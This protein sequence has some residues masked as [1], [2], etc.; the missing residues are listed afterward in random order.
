MTVRKHIGYIR[1][2]F[3][4]ECFFIINQL[5]KWLSQMYY[6]LFILVYSFLI[7]V[8][9]GRKSVFWGR[10]RFKRHQNSSIRI[11]KYCMFISKQTGNLLGLSKPCIVSTHTESAR[12]EIGDNCSFSGTSIS[13]FTSVVLKN[14][15][16]CGANT[17]IT[18]SDWHADDPRS[19]GSAP[20]CIGENVWLGMGATVLKGVTI[21]KNSLIGANSLVVKDIPENVIAAGNPCKVVRELP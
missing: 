1:T 12:I 14:N 2:D 9:I 11:G 16:R 21:G 18:D 5:S 20:V 4:G 17:T 10:I 3:R 19:S 6:K 7:D 13:A 8:K 15:V